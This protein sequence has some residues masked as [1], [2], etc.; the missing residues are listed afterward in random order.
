MPS[1]S[2]PLDAAARP[3]RA[4]R[5]AAAALA[6]LALLTLGARGE[7]PVP[8]LVFVS[9]QPIA[10]APGAI[11]GLGPRHRAVVT[12]G[13]LRM[14][15]PEGGIRPLLPE[16]RFLDV[17]DPAVAP[18]GKWVAFAAVAAADADSGWRIWIV[19]TDGADLRPVTTSASRVDRA[20]DSA[21]EAP[22][23]RHDDLDPCWVAAGLLCFASTRE[24]ARAQSGD[25]PATNL[26][27]VGRDGAGLTRLTAERNGADEPAYDPRTGRLVYARWWMNRFQAAEGG[28]GFTTDPSRAARREPVNLWQLVELDAATGAFRLAAGAVRTRAGTMGYQPAPLPNG[29]LAAVFAEH[30]GLDPAPGRTGIRVFTRRLE[31]GE[32]LAGASLSEQ[33]GDA[34]AGAEGLAAPAAVAPAALP[35]GRIVFAYDPGA[36][37]DFDLHVARPGGASPERLVDL[38]GTLELDPAPVVPWPAGARPFVPAAA[39]E[40]T[41]TYAC[42]D[43]FA[44]GP[45]GGPVPRGPERG[46]GSRLRVFAAR[47][48]ASGPDTAEL[49]REQAV[50]EDGRVVISGL[51]A[52]V[53]MFEQL[54]DARGVAVGTEAGPA[55]VEGFNWGAPG[56][57]VRCVGCHLGHSTLPAPRRT[58]ATRR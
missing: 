14:R 40:S 8:A 9:R 58:A 39:A 11:P 26:W 22:P 3:G 17:S 30:W 52:H 33:P 36:R 5:A 23:P 43:V 57:T 4:R 55:H 20:T 2:R 47:F 44:Q 21:N 31:R 54:V 16:G 29:A 49:I 35:D 27:L 18:D 56:A 45:R 19:S 15:T 7:P 50:A 42:E 41:F 13:V 32:R 53:P 24:S 37:G 38:P 25:A 51:P 48:R 34:Y 28:P 12:G 1:P 46:K 10:G 6:G